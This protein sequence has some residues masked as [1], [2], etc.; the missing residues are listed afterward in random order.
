MQSNYK[1]LPT[2]PCCLSALVISHSENFIP[3]I[4]DCLNKPSVVFIDHLWKRW[5][6]VSVCPGHPW[7]IPVALVKLLITLLFTLRIV[8]VW[9]TN[10]KLHG[11]PLFE[12]GD[13]T[14]YSFVSWWILCPRWRG[15]FWLCVFFQLNC[16]APRII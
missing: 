8:P 5:P 2:L 13:H 9:T 16:L 1:A 12:L 14:A 11:H 15:S 3:R 7:F 6:Y 10:Y 4:H